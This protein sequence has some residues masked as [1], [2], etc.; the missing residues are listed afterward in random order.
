M[1]S[2]VPPLVERLDPH[3]V[4]KWIRLDVS[5][6]LFGLFMTLS[7]HAD[8]LDNPAR[9]ALLGNFLYPFIGWGV[10]SYLIMWFQRNEER[11]GQWLAI[12]GI[13][14]YG[15]YVI[16]SLVLVGVLLAVGLTGI[17]PWLI[18]MIATV[19]STIFPSDLLGNSEGFQLANTLI[20]QE[21]IP[22]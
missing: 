7:F 14:S 6:S 16:H 3:L 8:L 13:N 9:F 5:A 21:H 11:F 12:A 10:M 18:A 17:N 1:Q 2:I 15:A 20:N 22:L 4:I 19:L